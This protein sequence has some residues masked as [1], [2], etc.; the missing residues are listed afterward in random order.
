MS[1][2][3]RS[4][5]FRPAFLLT[6][7]ISLLLV[8]SSIAMEKITLVQGISS[9][10]FGGPADG[11]S[12]ARCDSTIIM[13][14]WGSG[15]PFNGQFEASS[16]S[17]QVCAWNG[18]TSHD[19]NLPDSIYWHA[20]TYN[21]ANLNGH[22]AG[23]MAAWCG[24]MDF[25]ACS[26]A[27]VD[28]GYGNNMEDG[29]IWEAVV[30]DPSQP[31]LLTID[32]WLNYNVEPGY[33]FVSIGCIVNGSSDQV[34]MLALDGSG[35]NYHL[36][37]S[38][39]YQPGD[40]VGDLG[41][42]VRLEILVT[43]DGAYSDEDC[44]HAT[45]GAV[46]ID[47]IAVAV[48]NGSLYYFEDFESG[49]L[50]QWDPSVFAGVGD[51]ANL[52]SGLEGYIDVCSVNMS[53][54]VNF[55]DDGEV[56]PGT[57]GSM[58]IDWC[59]GPGGYVVNT[60]G[61]LAGPEYHLNNSVLSP[62]M[63][64][65]ENCSTGGVFSYDV[66]QH[67]DLSYDS[68]GIF[69]F[70]D[71]RSTTSTNPE[72]IESAVWEGYDF[73][74][75]MMG[76]MRRVHNVSEFL[77]PGAKF[78]Q[79]RLSVVEY[80]YNWGWDGNDASPAPY[81]D[82]VRLVAYDLGGPALSA[83]E[84]LLAND[85]FPASG[86]LD[87]Q[88][89]GNNSV[90]FDMATNI[91]VND[92]APVC[93]GDSIVMDASP[94]RDGATLTGPPVM[95]YRL[96][97]STTF[98]P[99]RTSGLP[100]LGSVTGSQ[101]ILGNGLLSETQFSFDLPDTG[102]LFPGDVMHYYFTASDEVG[103]LDME[104][105][106]LP[107]DTLGFSKLTDAMSYDQSYAFRALPTVQGFNGEDFETPLVLF[108]DDLGSDTKRPHYHYALNNTIGGV[109]DSYDV[110]YSNAA[111]SHVGNGL[112]RRATVAQLN[113]YDTII[114]AS[115]VLY[116]PTLTTVLEGSSEAPN[117]TVLE[118]WL[119]LGNKHLFL[120]GDEIASAMVAAGA[121]GQ[122]FMYDWMGAALANNDVRPLI[123]GQSTPMVKTMSGNPVFYQADT[124]IAYGGCPHINL[125][126]AVTVTNG[127]VPLAEFLAVDGSPGVFPYSAATLKINAGLQSAVISLPYDLS[128]IWDNPDAA[129]SSAS[130]SARAEMLGEI[131]SYFGL[132]NTYPTAA[133]DA[134]SFTTRNYPNPFNPK[135]RIEFNMPQNG[136]LKIRIFNIRG[137]QVRVLVDEFHV[138]GP[139]WVTWDGTDEAGNA[140]SAGVYF[141]E[142]R[143]SGNVDVGK[144]ALVK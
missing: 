31:A 92:L 111:S 144:M 131:L 104:T 5:S 119:A 107:A 118:S 75:Y 57:G 129:K 9:Q 19:N 15:A 76:Y 98:D 135:T 25:A 49:D 41:N 6:I 52:R 67:E 91:E 73:V 26:A 7:L 97:P 81:F 114:Y 136:Q 24:T 37:E 58:C 62:I 55:I 100:L 78:V 96:K 32:A 125:F 88:N 109:G 106:I 13:G 27:D 112:G 115:G 93:Y 43:S 68:P 2:Y 45:N 72:D 94:L 80:G 64:W 69:T 95:H 85:G 17:I 140:V 29:M 77:D 63:P 103:G 139:G 59:Y 74:Y 120:A 10:L 108:W 79:V 16:N 142:A 11:S 71:V 33:D 28:G 65:P 50:G 14:P 22:G 4:R 83:R 117:L 122:A 101:V 48:D 138:M 39:T 121:Q 60:T 143:T 86:S 20:D 82:N 54:Q 130:K 51:F 44:F 61:G 36:Q 21:A 35:E 3:L 105:S 90:R 18:W 132:G 113:A 127:G 141:Y 53:C 137:E 126:D 116:S 42:M 110:Y 70:W 123:G 99:Y 30:A 34:V 66:Y 1:T 89:P 56:V 134:I 38:F 102:F 46:Q 23:N 133:P 40:Y 12:K 8:S 47:D 87:T 124:W 84:H 128:F